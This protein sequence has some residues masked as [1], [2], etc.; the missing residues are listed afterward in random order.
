[1]PS[2]NTLLS[3]K[4]AISGSNLYLLRQP[5]G[6]SMITCTSDLSSLSN[7]GREAAA[8]PLLFFGM[9]VSQD[10][11]ICHSCCQ[12]GSIAGIIHQC[13]VQCVQQQLR[14][15]V[16]DSAAIRGH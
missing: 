7:A 5:L 9:N 16:C 10:Y 3:L 4:A 14:R 2:G 11:G 6:V 1:M 15:V 12:V 8:A 13:L